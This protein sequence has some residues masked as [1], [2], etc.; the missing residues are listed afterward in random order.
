MNLF[1][2]LPGVLRAVAKII[3][4]DSVDKAAAALEQA[5]LTPEQQA[6]VEQ[7]LIAQTVSIRQLDVEELKT[8][9]SESIAEIQ[10]ADKYVARARPTGLYLFYL[11][12]FATVVAEIAGV[13]IDPTVILATLGPLG[14]VGGTYVYRRT[15]EKLNGSGG[16]GD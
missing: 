6:A 14:G 2:L 15:T 4:I 16:S 11:A 9:M 8:V 10:S 7:A 3:G 1:K 13:K 12:T 5:Q